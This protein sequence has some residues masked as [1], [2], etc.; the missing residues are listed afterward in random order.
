MNRYPNVWIR[1]K[2]EKMLKWFTA[3]SATTVEARLVTWS[4]ESYPIGEVV[5]GIV[6]LLKDWKSTNNVQTY[7]DSCQWVAFSEY[8]A[9]VLIG[10][11]RG[12]GALLSHTP[13]RGVVGGRDQ[14]HVGPHFEAQS[15]DSETN[16]R[17]RLVYTP[18]KYAAERA[19]IRESAP[20][21]WICRGRKKK[22]GQFVA[23]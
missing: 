9:N 4:T 1:L 13:K 20:L 19:G 22:K 18:R 11:S 5:L 3:S 7:R 21:K 2:R 15:L 23:L 8:Q 17:S 16:R 12:P 6:S 10:F 14:T